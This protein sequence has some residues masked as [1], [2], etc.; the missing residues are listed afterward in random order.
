MIKNVLNCIPAL[1]LAVGAAGCL[2]VPSVSRG[3]EPGTVGFYGMAPVQSRVA[4]EDTVARR[5]STPGDRLYVY[6]VNGTMVSIGEGKTSP[7]AKVV[8]LDEAAAGTIITPESAKRL[9]A[10][11]EKAIAAYDNKNKKESQYMDFRVL[12][13]GE[14][15]SSSSKDGVPA[16]PEEYIQMRFQYVYNEGVEADGEVVNYYLG[17][18]KRPNRLTYNEIKILLSSLQKP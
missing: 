3:P 8:P 1:L 6:R 2:S 12:A 18:G 15:S 10:W 5:M 7:G 9:A 4:T 11:L 16:V 14:V 13:N 17:G